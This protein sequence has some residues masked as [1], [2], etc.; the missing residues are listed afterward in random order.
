MKGS[1][2]TQERVIKTWK[3]RS[4][5]EEK[6]W[7]SKHGLGVNPKT[8]KKPKGYHVGLRIRGSSITT[9]LLSQER[10]NLVTD[11]HSA[12]TSLKSRMVNYISG[13]QVTFA[14]PKERKDE[15][16]ELGYN[17]IRHRN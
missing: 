15:S 8:V 5:Q 7:G 14:V 6:D 9:D 17:P 11:G 10:M 12:K 1:P 3:V 16:I 2:S 4:Y 13:I